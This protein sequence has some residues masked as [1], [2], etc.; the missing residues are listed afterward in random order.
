MRQ[1]VF[2]I[3]ALLLSSCVE[4]YQ[5]GKVHTKL[6][7]VQGDEKLKDSTIFKSIQAYK[8]SLSK[9]MDVVIVKSEQNMFGGRPESLLTNFV[10][11]F[12]L[13]EAPSYLKDKSWNPHIALMNR[14]GLRNPISEGDVTVGN[15]FELMPFDNTLVI[16]KLKANVLRQLCDRIAKRGGEG[17]SGMTMEINDGKAQNILINNKPIDDTKTYNLV[18]NDY[19]AKGGDT[20]SMLN[21]NVGFLDTGVTVRD[22]II[23]YFKKQN[24]AGKMLKSALDGRIITK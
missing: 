13:E 14:G 22:A 24:A 10:S 18:T 2:F 17:I 23:A 8:K 12:V 11:D 1:L 4:N 5:K 7:P 3:I 21:D 9:K 20:M 19:V 16:L 15:V 6:I